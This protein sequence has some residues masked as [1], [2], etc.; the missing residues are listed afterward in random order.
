MKKNT[1][2]VTL[3]LSKNYMKYFKKTVANNGF[4]PGGFSSS[5]DSLRIR[6]M[7]VSRRTILVKPPARRKAA[8]RCGAFDQKIV[9]NN[10]VKRTIKRTKL[11]NGKYRKWN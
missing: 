3:N 7:L 1:N 6:E 5:V 8:G 4:A 9:L 11:Q 10:K 2:L